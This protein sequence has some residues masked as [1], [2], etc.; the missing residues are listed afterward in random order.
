[1]RGPVAKAVAASLQL[2]KYRNV[3]SREQIAFPD[4]YNI[5]S[6]APA[7][8]MTCFRIVIQQLPMQIL[9]STALCTTRQ[10]TSKS[11]GG[12]GRKYDACN[13][14]RSVATGRGRTRV[15]VPCEASVKYTDGTPKRCTLRHAEINIHHLRT[16]VQL[17]MAGE[18]VNFW[19]KVAMPKLAATFYF[20]KNSIRNWLAGPCGSRNRGSVD[21][22]AR[23]KRSSNISAPGLKAP[24]AC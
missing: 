20:L 24:E 12:G 9:I 23:G 13:S 17:G 2:A 3:H 15:C 14:N 16:S 18:G 5:L 21:R 8:E 10:P 6:P 7:C 19:R 11:H 1:M 22:E 4:H